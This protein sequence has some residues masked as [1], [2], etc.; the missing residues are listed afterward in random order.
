MSEVTTTACP[1]CGAQVSLGHAEFVSCPYCG[2]EVRRTSP[3]GKQLL[4]QLGIRVADPAMREEYAARVK[5]AL[6]ARASKRRTAVVG[7][8]LGIVVAVVAV[9]AGLWWRGRG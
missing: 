9:V 7:A 6:E 1:S 3:T 8:V 5:A 2:A 4:G